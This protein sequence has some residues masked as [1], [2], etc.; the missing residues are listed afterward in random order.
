MAPQAGPT[1][2]SRINA[3]FNLAFAMMA[4]TDWEL[5]ASRPDASLF[6]R[7]CPWGGHLIKIDLKNLLIED[8]PEKATHLLVRP[9][10]RGQHHD[11]FFEENKI[12]WQETLAPGD[13]LVEQAATMFILR[14]FLATWRVAVLL[15]RRDAWKPGHQLY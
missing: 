4:D 11:R 12:E 13:A 7:A 3:W 14:C 15:C 8:A 9:E 10:V 1:E 6:Y 5:A 2:E